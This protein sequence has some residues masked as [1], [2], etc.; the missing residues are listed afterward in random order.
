VSTATA[1]AREAA[2]LNVTTDSLPSLL[3]PDGPWQVVQGFWP[4]AK[5]RTQET[6]LYLDARLV[7]DQRVSNQRIR[8]QYQFSIK[9]V[10]PI[11]TTVPPIAETEQQNAASAVELVRQRI[12]GLVGDKTHGGAFLSVAENPRVI[13]IAWADPEVTI[14][15]Q[16]AIRCVI[17]YRADDYE[18]SG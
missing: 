18:V 10:W 16:K 3:A 4:G 6:G 17:S 7:D 12:S 8:D 13:S 1:V 5:L 11:R 14:P 2:W 15:E 9:V